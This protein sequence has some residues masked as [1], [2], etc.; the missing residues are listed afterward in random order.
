MA[1]VWQH[2]AGMI[3]GSVPVCKSDRCSCHASCVCASCLLEGMPITQL[4][5]AIDGCEW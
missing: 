5:S 3:R 2:T 4:V 1:Q